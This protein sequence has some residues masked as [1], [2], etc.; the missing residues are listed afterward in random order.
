[1]IREINNRDNPFELQMIQQMYR[2]PPNPDFGIK[3]NNNTNTVNNVSPIG[4]INN[5]DNIR[6]ND[7]IVS[8][9]IP[10]T[11]V[12]TDPKSFKQDVIGKTDKSRGKTEDKEAEEFKMPASYYEDKTKIS[13]DTKEECKLER[14]SLRNPELKKNPI[15]MQAFFENLESTEEPDYQFTKKNQGNAASNPT[16]GQSLMEKLNGISI[17][18]AGKPWD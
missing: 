7:M 8:Q 1:M 13:S 17:A 11:D 9:N 14:E 6:A 18:T 10:Q 5:S 4:A 15:N 16:Q 3:D 2:M 12:Q